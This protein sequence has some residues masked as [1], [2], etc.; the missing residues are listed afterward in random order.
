M[1]DNPP[2][3]DETHPMVCNA[4]VPQRGNWATKL[5]GKQLLTTATDQNETIRALLGQRPIV[6]IGMMGSGKSAIGKMVADELGLQFRDS[7]AEIVAAAGMSV[8][9]IFSK[10]GED[11]FRTGEARVVARLLAEGEG[12]LSLGGGAFVSAET[13][14]LVAQKAVSIWLKAD[15]D[16]LLSRVMR[17]PKSRPLLQTADP[18]TTLAD[19]LGKRTP[20]YSLADIH[21]ES[22]RMSKRETCDDV[23]SGL[24]Y[25]LSINP[26]ANPVQA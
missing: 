21:V 11:H 13:R 26:P 10:F 8:P 6:F 15:A 25:W 19:L 24:T 3:L 7:D 17:R 5:A 12:V 23:L 1:A 9:E 22:S 16:L 2:G 14:A 4:S 18:R 20:V